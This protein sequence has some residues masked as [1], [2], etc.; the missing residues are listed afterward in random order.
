MGRF[1]KKDEK[2]CSGESLVLDGHLVEIG[3]Q[4]EDQKPPTDLNV[5]GK[6]CGVAGKRDVVDCRTKIPTITKFHAGKTAGG[7]SQGELTKLSDPSYKS[8]N[9]KLSGGEAEPK[10]SVHDILSSLRQPSEQKV[11]SVNKPF[12]E[13]NCVRFSRVSVCTNNHSGTE[14]PEEYEIPEDG[15]VPQARSSSFHLRPRTV[16]FISP[17]HDANSSSMESHAE[18]AA[19]VNTASQKEVESESLTRTYNNQ[20]LEIIFPCE[21]VVTGSNAALENGSSSS[22]SPELQEDKKGSC[23]RCNNDLKETSLETKDMDEIP[24]FDLRL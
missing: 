17:I 7:N 10:R 3:E 12:T 2:I 16:N 13:E 18:E 8:E 23:S 19:A 20:E 24:S 14:I 15:I 1:L 22:K 6:S 4:E 11:V 9:A 5:L 21:E